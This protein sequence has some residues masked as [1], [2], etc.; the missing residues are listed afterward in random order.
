[1][2][3]AVVLVGTPI[4]CKNMNVLT[5]LLLPIILRIYGSLATSTNA[6]IN[7]ESLSEMNAPTP[8]F[9]YSLV[10]DNDT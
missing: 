7:I 10:P 6:L 3:I 1:M 8:F 2:N 9:E 4:L 5:T